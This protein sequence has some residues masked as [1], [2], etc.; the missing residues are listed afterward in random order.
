MVLREL[1]DRLR[2]A[3]S[4]AGLTQEQ[5][6]DLAGISRPRYRDIETG[7][8]AARTTT[9]MNVSRALGLEMM[10]VPQSMV[11]AVQAL[12]RPQDDEDLPAFVPQPD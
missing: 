7:A 8:A 6:A 11:P 12:L 4:D 10:L 1:G 5:V 9:L 2:Q 3:R